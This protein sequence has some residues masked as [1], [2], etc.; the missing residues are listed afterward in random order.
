M[1]R[2]D[3]L[4]SRARILEIARGRDLGAL[5]HNDIAREAHVG[6]ATVYRHFPTVRD[7]IEAL[8]IDSLRR[9]RETAEIADAEP[10]AL[11]ALR[12]F[13]SAALALQLEDAGLQSVLANLERIDPVIHTECSAA[14]TQVHDGYAR[15]LARA[16]S[17]GAVRA[18]LTAPQLQRM[19]SGI[20]HAVRLGAP[21]DAEMLLDVFFAGL[22]TPAPA[23]TALAKD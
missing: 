22:C 16:Q 23:P 12:G 7:L 20:E 13:L 14:R 18:D 11:L 3:A 4:R 19:L 5:R 1:P 2:S 21:A 6:V 17:A 15:V 9:L 10:D 8:S